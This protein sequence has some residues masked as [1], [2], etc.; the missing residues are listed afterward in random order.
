MKNGISQGNYMKRQTTNVNRASDLR[1][2]LCMQ[3]LLYES[4]FLSLNAYKLHYHDFLVLGEPSRKRPAAP[5]NADQP[6]K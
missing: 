3:G 4:F 5:A 1:K 2:L 6:G